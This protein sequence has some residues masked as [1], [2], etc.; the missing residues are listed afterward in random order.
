V[1]NS[2]VSDLPLSHLPLTM[3]LAATVLAGTTVG[4]LLHE[5]LV[6]K[7]AETTGTACAV[8]AQTR[9][10]HQAASGSPVQGPKSRSRS[11]FARSGSLC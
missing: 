1:G 10:R 8:G 4:V 3:T 7:R 9:A 11:W 2:G 5:D 6:V